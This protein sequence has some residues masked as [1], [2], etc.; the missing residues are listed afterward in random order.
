MK[1]LLLALGILALICSPALAGKNAGGAMIVHTNDAV[2]YTN[3]DFCQD[4]YK[5]ADCAS[6][7]TRS[8]KDAATETLIWFLAAF[9]EGADAVVAGVQFGVRHNLPPGQGY[10][11]HWS[12]CPTD[13]LVL[14]DQGFPD[15]PGGT[16]IGRL[17]PIAGNFQTFAWFGA[18]QN[19][20]GSFFGSGVY[21]G[22]GLAKFA[23]D[24]VPPVED[25]CFL[26]GE[27]R[28]MEAGYNDCPTAPVTGACCYPDG[29]C[30][31]LEQTACTGDFM[32]EGTTCD[33]NPCEQPQACCFEDGSCQNLLAA[34]CTL[35]GG[36]PE[37]EGTN[38][39]TFV[40]PTPPA[41]CCY[42]DGSCEV[43][44]AEQCEANG[45][46]FHPEWPTC[47]VAECPIPPTPG[48]CCIAGECTVILEDDCTAQ[49]GLWMNQETCEGVECPPPVATESTTWGQIKA[50]Y[51]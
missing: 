43:L 17:A 4:Q 8:D 51:R 38:C 25:L 1:K 12:A 15:T 11:P 20:A 14:P 16:L 26:F 42:D 32:G 47:D 45:G 5:P 35:A 50:N 6:A 41:A 34:D 21:P 9:P 23:D 29:T 37:G 44:T 24:S 31:V 33:P 3:L 13:A 46:T 39:D 27:V 48:A 36:T 49:G 18:Y 10:V 28:W 19:G 40:C 22:D 2:N 30:E 7:V